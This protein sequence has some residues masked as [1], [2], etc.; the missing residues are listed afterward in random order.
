MVCDK[1]PCSTVEASEAWR[2]S[3]GYLTRVPL[4]VRDHFPLWPR[5]LKET[6][7]RISGLTYV[8]PG[9]STNRMYRRLSPNRNHHT[10]YMT[11][12]FIG[13]EWELTSEF[14]GG[15]ACLVEGRSAPSVRTQVGER[16]GWG[17]LSGVL[18]TIRSGRECEHPL[19]TSSEASGVGGPG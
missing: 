14:R 9:Q 11:E 6:I 19:L 1:D 8:F 4:L 12:H 15:E 16:S 5:Q 13:K 17:L 2:R 18:H 3:L 10:H 7:M